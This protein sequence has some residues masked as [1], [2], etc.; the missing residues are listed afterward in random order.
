MKIN[1]L[2]ITNYKLRNSLIVALDVPT[3]KEARAVFDELRETDCA[4]KIGLQLFTAA[5][6]RFVRELIDAGAKIFLDL[7]FH[8][9][10]NTVANAGAEAARL[11]VWMFNVHA[12]GGREMM[13][14]T[15]SV[16]RETAA[17]ENF[18]VPKIIAVTVLTS[19]NI[20]TLNEVGIANE[21]LSQVLK[22]TN[23][24]SNCG[25]DGVVASA[26]EA[27][28]IKMNNELRM[29]N[30]APAKDF[31][32]ITPGIRFD[33]KIQNSKFKIERD[34]QQ[35]TLTPSEAIKAGA[36]YLVVGRPIL[37]AANK[38]ETVREI[39]AQIELV[40]E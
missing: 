8:D 10:P 7:K 24:A 28:Q 36:D 3:A 16:V 19:S 22:L 33:S 29:T 35:R 32:I 17:K 11:G 30:D 31:L 5:G 38:L 27:P 20:E 14:R 34:D 1:E 9:I 39:L 2:Q 37:Q 23:L 6:S 13:E 4:F 40:T 15:V 26:Q 18:S 12:F 25:L 21:P